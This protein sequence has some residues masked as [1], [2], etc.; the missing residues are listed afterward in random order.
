[1]KEQ[2]SGSSAIRR[3]TAEGPGGA[4]VGCGDDSCL[5]VVGTGGQ[6]KLAWDDGSGPSG[7]ARV[8]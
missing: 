6:K 2:G 4:E 1:M 7:W 3:K 8:A 5:V